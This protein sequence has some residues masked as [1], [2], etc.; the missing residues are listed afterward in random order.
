[1]SETDDHAPSSGDTFAEDT[2][3][4]ETGAASPAPDASNPPSSGGPDDTTTPSSGDETELTERD[5]LL[6][7]VKSAIAP[8]ADAEAPGTDAVKDASGNPVPAPGAPEAN[9]DPSDNELRAY[10]PG[11]R[12]RILQLL[13]QRKEASA[14]LDAVQPELSAHRQLV[15]YLEQH[16]LA[17]DDVNLLLGVGAALRRGDYA[18]FLD[19]LEPYRQVA[20]QAL[21]RTAAPDLQAQI[22]D[23]SMSED[24]ARELTRTRMEAARHRA[25][26]ETQTQRLSERDTQALQGQVSRAVQD[27]ENALRA[28]DPDYALKE[29]LIQSTSRGLLAA[30]GGLRSPA[31]AV[32]IAQRAYDEVT[33]AFT[34]GRPAPRPT[35]PAL[36]SAS[37][38]ASSAS[39]QPRSLMEAAMQGLEKARRGA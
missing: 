18:S 6:A 24:A 33:A 12:K 9:Q 10:S 16:Q 32:A 29:T 19:G 26:A 25:E 15:G 37:N 5:G 7:A 11:A 4:P 23:G 31:D 36:S 39:A 2:A 28:R 27:W 22:D 35:R 20:L 13:G 14:A 8:K 30:A 1:M 21:G 34:R 38:A 3:A 17:P